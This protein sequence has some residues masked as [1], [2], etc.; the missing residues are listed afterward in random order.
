MDLSLTNKAMQPMSDFAIQFNKNTYVW[1]MGVFSE[2]GVLL[3]HIFLFVCCLAG[4][5]GRTRLLSSPSFRQSMFSWVS[6]LVLDHASGIGAH[7]LDAAQRSDAGG[8]GYK[9]GPF[10]GTGCGRDATWRR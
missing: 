6:T 10:V 1:Q 7:V 8:E 2:C 5:C 4:R 3:A 9:P